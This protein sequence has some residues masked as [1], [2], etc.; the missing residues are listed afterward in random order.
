[1]FRRDAFG[2]VSDPDP[3]SQHACIE[4]RSRQ[5]PSTLGVSTLPLPVRHLEPAARS[6]RPRPP[7]G[8]RAT[9][10]S[11]G[12][13]GSDC[14]R[15]RLDDE[16]AL[17]G[18]WAP[19]PSTGVHDDPRGR[20][21]QVQVQLGGWRT[22]RR[23]SGNPDDAGPRMSCLH[24]VASEGGSKRA[25]FLAVEVSRESV[26]ARPNLPGLVLVGNVPKV[27]DVIYGDSPHLRRPPWVIGRELSLRRERPG[28]TLPQTR[29]PRFAAPRWHRRGPRRGGRRQGRGSPPT[30]AR[31]QSP[32]PHPALPGSSRLSGRGARR[33]SGRKLVRTLAD[34]KAKLAHLKLS[35]RVGSPGAAPGRGWRP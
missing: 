16:R 2:A 3:S 20:A 11:S 1:M 19:S 8:S 18:F 31:A 30:S 5:R 14:L 34:S 12:A 33:P 23:R 35:C 4:L 28:P 9:P 24:A 13:Q 17:I 6:T 15:A 25:C 7:L 29:Y 27:N 10:D 21:R 32:P 22:R 26:T